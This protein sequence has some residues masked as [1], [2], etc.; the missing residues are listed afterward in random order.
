MKLPAIN[1]SFKHSS[2]PN[3]GE[4]LSIVLMRGIASLMVCFFHLSYGDNTYLPDSS[5]IKQTGKW[6]WT[7]VEIFFIISG[8][9]IP[10]SMYIKNY[11]YR[12][13]GSFFKKRIIRI[14][15]PYLISI[16]MVLVLGYISSLMPFYGGK[17]FEIDWLNVLG[18]VAYLNVFTGAK[19]LQ[20]VYWTLAVEF[21]YYVLVAVSYSLLVSKKRYARLSF[22]AVFMLSLLLSRLLPFFIF[23]FATYF[24]LGI[25]LFQLYTSIIPAIEFWILLV[26]TIGLSFHFNGPELTGISIVTIILI[27]L[28][29]RVHP[30]FIFLGTISY[31]LYLVHIP[32]GGRFMSIALKL[33]PNS[34]TIKELLVFAGI[35]VSIVM[36]WGYYV[37]VE[38]RFKLLASRIGY[39]KKQEPILKP[40]FEE[41]GN[42]V[43]Q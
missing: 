10:Y 21:Q 2:D 34:V 3:K 17:P 12:D 11:S 7:G 1:F 40:V 14:E 39:S 6:G 15:P 4:I 8:F 38:K 5:I 43:V 13:M 31:S 28:V 42:T 16:V 20:D 29:K 19:W 41:T 22:Y 25:L 35:I 27:T 32:L 24:M 36:A 18:H 33:L 9:V 26:C 37:L 30:F 23:S